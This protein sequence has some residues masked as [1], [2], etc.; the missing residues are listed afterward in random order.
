MAIDNML[1]M[2][3]LVGDFGPQV[4]AAADKD[5]RIASA[6]MSVA[7]KV[8]K[9]IPVIGSLGGDFI[10]LMSASTA[11]IGLTTGPSVIDLAKVK[12]DITN[13]LHEIF[14]QTGKNIDLMNQKI[15]N[16][17]GAMDLN[18]VIDILKSMRGQKFS[19]G[20]AHPIAKIMEGGSFLVPSVPKTAEGGI[21]DGM[22]SVKR[23]II[24]ALLRGT[25]YFVYTSTDVNPEACGQKY[26]FQHID[27]KC[28]GLYLQEKGG[29]YRGA[30]EIYDKMQTYGINMVEFYKNVVD[31]NNG[32]V[33]E[34]NVGNGNGYQKCF[35]NLKTFSDTFE[36]PCDS[37]GWRQ[38]PELRLTDFICRQPD[39]PEVVPCHNRCIRGQGWYGEEDEA[40]S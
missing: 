21:R 11:L 13:Q 8:L 18:M 28:Y 40:E 2:D 31:C 10:G 25:G 38:F 7:E 37:E 26:G 24:G 29:L 6:S 27:G 3:K 33:G 34:E 35:F 1:E 16:G 30:Q 20:D 32:E 36:S 17:K 4:S 15:L 39:P 23:S 9:N 14:T 5:F 19:E 12:E 22:D